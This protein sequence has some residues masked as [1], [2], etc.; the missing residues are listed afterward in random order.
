M[1]SFGTAVVGKGLRFL[2]GA[3]AQTYFR[4]DELRRRLNVVYGTVN[5]EKIATT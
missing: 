5:R 3:L 2:R 1:T 4:A